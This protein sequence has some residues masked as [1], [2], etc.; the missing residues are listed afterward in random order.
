MDF[1][2]IGFQNTFIT[3]KKSKL[4]H[5]LDPLTLFDMVDVLGEL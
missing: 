3:K 1:D 4:L 2:Q 5:G